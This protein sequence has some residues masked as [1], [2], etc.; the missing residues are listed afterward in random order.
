MAYDIGLMIK[1]IRTK[2]KLTQQEFALDLNRIEPKDIKIR[3]V[4][5]SNYEL[6]R[7]TPN[8]QKFLKI[9]EYGQQLKSTYLD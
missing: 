8:A 7:H 4:D 5:I 1:I 3:P 2:A 6:G 9:M